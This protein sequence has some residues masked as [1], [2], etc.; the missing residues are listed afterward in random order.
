MFMVCAAFC[1]AVVVEFY[2][3]SEAQRRDI[4]RS[5][6]DSVGLCYA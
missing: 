4:L 5:M 6:L 1:L 2:R 3:Y